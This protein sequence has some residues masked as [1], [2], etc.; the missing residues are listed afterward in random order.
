MAT[1]GPQFQLPSIQ[2]KPL[3]PP[4][5]KAPGSTGQPVVG[6]PTE[7]VTLSQLPTVP[8]AVPDQAPVAE[9][10]TVAIPSQ[11]PSVPLQVGGLQVS[12]NQN[13]GALYLEP[14][15]APN[16]SLEWA[17]RNPLAKA[18]QH[19]AAMVGAQGGFMGGAGAAIA[20]A[21]QKIG[22]AKKKPTEGAVDKGIGSVDPERLQQATSSPYALA[23]RQAAAG[24]ASTPKEQ[25]QGHFKMLESALLDPQVTVL[26]KKNLG[27]GINGTYLVTLSNGAKA[28]FK[29]TAGE[30]QSKLRNQLEEDHQG[31]REEAAYLVD[32]AMG[33]IG[34]VPPTVRRS[35]DGQEG[36]LMLFVPEAE[37]A[38]GSGKVNATMSK[39]ESY[40][41]IAVLDNVIGNLD[42]HEGNWM[43]TKDNEA[44]PI[45]H[46]LAFPW[47]NESQGFL[48]YD[49]QKEVS[50]SAD[51]LQGLKQLS[52]QRESLTQRLSSLLEKPAI[53]SMFERVDRMVQEQKT[54]TWWLGENSKIGW[55]R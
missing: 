19:S 53:D 38:M 44:M 25:V 9:Q 37:V 33:H 11:P 2:F 41:R 45:D 32:K 49:F 55:D 10:A 3:P 20:R 4:A 5:R 17:P 40:R 21:F 34:R 35:I 30:D 26:E 15:P 1:I 8:L 16:I 14:P 7:Q 13:L 52:S 51:D 36:A 47:K 18:G 39:G 42:R 46:G 12:G 43:V 27:G 23:L 54:S 31:K 22:F 6:E 50:L 28:V 48:N 24:L 29:P